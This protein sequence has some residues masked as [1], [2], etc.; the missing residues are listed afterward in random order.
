[1]KLTPH[2]QKL[3]DE[4]LNEGGDLRDLAEILG[5]SRGGIG[6]VVSGHC[7]RPI[8]DIDFSAFA[9]ESYIDDDYRM[10]QLVAG[11]EPTEEE[12]EVWR[13]AQRDAQDSTR[14]FIWKVPFSRESLYLITIHSKN[15]YIDKVDGPFHSE[16]ASLPFGEIVYD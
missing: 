13:Q 15:G 12:M 14:F 5:I 7:Y 16:E 11:S 8:K 2:A 6:A 1:M 10:R 3:A 9:I 4:W